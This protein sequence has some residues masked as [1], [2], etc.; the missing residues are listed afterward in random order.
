VTASRTLP[1][2]VSKAMPERYVARFIGR[3]C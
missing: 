2:M 1:T 3:I